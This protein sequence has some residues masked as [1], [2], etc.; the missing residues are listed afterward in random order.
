VSHVL[1]CTPCL[2]KALLQ[3]EGSTG[4]KTEVVKA[5]ISWNAYKG[6][7]WKLLRKLSRALREQ[8][9]AQVIE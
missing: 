4:P 7:T 6:G 9:K 8:T 5:K 3:R 2:I 1:L